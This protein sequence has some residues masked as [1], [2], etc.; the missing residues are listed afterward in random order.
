MSIGLFMAVSKVSNPY[1][2]LNTPSSSLLSWKDRT[3]K[4]TQG[5]FKSFQSLVND[6]TSSWGSF[7]GSS[8]YGIGNIKEHK[9][10]RQLILKSTPE[11]KDF[12][13]LEIGAGNFQWGKALAKYLSEQNDLPKDITIHIIGIRGESNR[14]KT[15][16]DLGQ[17]KLYE[18]G[19]FPVE[20]LMDEFQ[21]RGLQLANKV[22]LVVSNYCFRHLV[23]PIGTFIQ[24]YDLLRPQTGHMLFDGF[25]FLFEND[26]IDNFFYERMVQLALETRAPFLAKTN[27]DLGNFILRKPDDQP[28]RLRTSYVGIKNSGGLREIHSETIT[29]FKEFPEG[30]ETMIPPLRENDYRGNKDLYERLKQNELLHDLSVLWSP[31]LDEDSHK[32]KPP[33]HTAIACGNEENIDRCLMEG[34][35][36]NESDDNGATPLHLAIQYNNFNLFSQ[37]MQKGAL[38]I[39]FA[40]GY[41]PLHV[42]AQHDLDGRF[43]KKLIESGADVNRRLP[44][45]APFSPLTCAI[46]FKNVKA[47]ELLLE[48]KATV[49]YQDHKA[50]SGNPN[51]TSVQ[52]LLPK[53]LNQLAGFDTIADHLQKGDSVILTYPG[54]RSGCKIFPS[55]KLTATNQLIR[56]TV[57]PETHV[58]HDHTRDLR[59]EM[60]DAITS[61]PVDVEIYHNNEE[62]KKVTGLE[63]RLGY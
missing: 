61:T 63:L 53:R 52:S 18:F 2:A 22:D 11:C 4:I 45:W 6:T 49:L 36:I 39:F 16:N 21:K 44:S 54:S 9:L 3:S 7:N 26:E 5:I 14:D 1:T 42:A 8:E 29:L 24:A 20:T 23:D 28:C 46:K 59:K 17:C 10:M 31:L 50:L 58:L 55:N 13:A 37:L 32:K 35:D 48:A 51:F 60:Q 40:N 34:C 57:N 38:T 19:E 15:V 27:N 56:V 41:T 12:Y 62:I 43:I 30:D 47:V 33:L 25:F